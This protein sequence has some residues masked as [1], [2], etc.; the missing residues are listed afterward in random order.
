MNRVNARP[1]D[2]SVT[3]PCCQFRRPGARLK[4][5]AH[6]SPKNSPPADPPLAGFGRVIGRSRYVVLM[7]V[8]AVLLVSLTLFVLGA[9]NAFAVTRSAKS[10]RRK[11][12]SRRLRRS[13]RSQGSSLSI[14]LT[15]SDVP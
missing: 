1:G 3:A 2:K 6:D 7:A 12:A 13:T 11:L 14:P 10:A 15:A 9:L 4:G 8:V 5:V